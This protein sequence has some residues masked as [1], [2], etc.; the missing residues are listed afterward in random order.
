MS[1]YRAHRA[2]RA[3]VIAAK[4]CELAPI[5]YEVP[6]DFADTEQSDEMPELVGLDCPMPGD[7]YHHMPGIPAHPRKEES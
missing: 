5:P 4:Q 7:S 6:R 2:V 1:H 3:S